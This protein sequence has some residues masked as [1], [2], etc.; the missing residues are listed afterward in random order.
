[1]KFKK[2]FIDL[3]YGVLKPKIFIILF[4]LFFL[5]NTNLSIAEIVFTQEVAARPDHVEPSYTNLGGTASNSDALER[6]Q[7]GT[8]NDNG[9]LV[10]FLN[11]RIDHT[12]Q[13]T[14]MRLSTPYDLRTASRV[15]EGGDPIIDIAGGSG[16]S[17]VTLDIDFNNDGTK[18]FLTALTG[19]VFPFDLQ[20]PYSFAFNSGMSFTADSEVDL[21]A[22]GELEFNNDGT[23]MY[24]VH[25]Q[26]NPTLDEYTLTT[27]FDISSR[28][29]VNTQ[30]LSAKINSAL[31]NKQ[32]V[33][34]F[35]FNDTGRSMYVLIRDEKNNNDT[36]FQYQLR[37]AFD[38]STAVFIGKA[39]LDFGLKVGTF[40]NNIGVVGHVFNGLIFS[41]D[42]SKMYIIND[43]GQDHAHQLSLSC[44]FGV[45]A[46]VPDTA[47]NIGSQV[48]LASKNIHHN[49]SNIFKRFE[50]LRR[51]KDSQ[52]LSNHNIKFNIYNPILASLVKKKQT[53]L[54]KNKSSRVKTNWSYWSH[55]DISFTDQASTYQ[56]KPK[57][58]RTSGLM[59][60]GDRKFGVNN[61]FGAA[62]RY[63]K[64][65]AKILSSNQSMGTD[66]LTLNF[67]GTVAPSE[68][69]YTNALIGL[70]IL[71]IDQKFKGKLTGERN[72]KQAFA[73]LN[74]RSKNNFGI[75]K[76][77][78][79][80]KISYGVTSLSD[81]TDFLS[82]VTTG[83]NDIHESQMFEIGNAAIGFLFHMEP[84]EIDTGTIRTHGGLEYVHDISPTTTF[85]HSN[86][87]GA[88]ST[89]IGKYSSKNYKGN[90]GFESIFNNGFTFS[91]NYERLQHLD[92][93]RSGRTDSF[94]FKIGH[95]DGEDGEFA[96]IYNPI[97]NDQ[98]ELSYTKNINGFDLKINSNY[99]LASN[100][101][102]YGA[103]IEVSSTF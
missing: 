45:A 25:G 88:Q 46:C 59:F 34:G 81:Y 72:G 31:T 95:T 84:V 78:P 48:E 9:T 61:F 1:M 14:V 74:F 80:A 16:D 58:I 2:N 29:L 67:Y 20:I 62:I 79:S 70:S 43:S 10:F 63:G 87:S 103:N 19:E 24:F 50:W 23:K 8:F 12:D 41:G 17:R 35:A 42:G 21:G 40:Y 64:D 3:K 86:L 37:I 60:G 36:I 27:A 98:T 83:V 7:G 6:P 49:T 96:L 92:K 97:Q 101:P 52:N 65:N 32:V 18:L 26:D 75:L 30:S 94:L 73:A 71:R 51:N 91:I 57:K 11:N 55:G 66:S 56:I 89:K 85:F 90:I 47:S 28:T 54:K 5:F 102:D 4:G 38:T 33:T 77:D 44:N 99:S 68:S 39:D 82:N 69:T 13:V 53:S 22:R 93:D 15:F 100:I 76:L